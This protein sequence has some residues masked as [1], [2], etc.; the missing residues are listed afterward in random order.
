M[1]PY[2][3]LVIIP[4]FLQ[5]WLK[6]SNKLI[7]IGNFPHKIT[8]KNVVL[9]VFFLLFILLL[10][11]RDDTVGRDLANYNY[12]FESFGNQT[13]TEIISDRTEVLFHLYC[14]AFY[15]YISQNYQIFISVTAILSVLPIAYVYM[16]DKTYGYMKMAIFVNMSTFIMLFSGIR[17][18]LAMAAGMMAYQALEEKKNW[19]FLIWA[20]V[21]IFT[22]HTGFMVLFMFPLCRIKFSKKNLF[23]ILPIGIF[24][25]IFNA[26]I[27][28]LLSLLIGSSNEKYLTTAESTGAIG[29]FILFL[30]FTIF[31]YLIMDE[32]NMDEEAFALRNILVFATFLQTFASQNT[33]AMRMNYYFILLIPIAVGKSVK[34]AS[35]KYKQ[36]ANVGKIIICIYFTINFIY[37]IYN[38]YITGISTLDTVPYIP[39]WKGSV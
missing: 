14:W 5:I 2:Y 7:C 31:V 28:N 21:A 9:P 19:K 29:S 17:Q 24:V 33:L 39:F 18:G 11:L 34:Y 8:S 1:F 27:F 26:Q 23:W 6:G 37:G 16:K 4:L 25:L 38:S 12:I 30:L 10:A 3:A 15:N 13:F 22:H 36:I 32:S 35:D 20:L